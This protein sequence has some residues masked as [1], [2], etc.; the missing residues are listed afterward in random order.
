MKLN[1][2][3]GSKGP[4][5]CGPSEPDADKKYYPSLH[6]DEENPVD[7]PK[8][9]TMVV[10]FRKTGSSESEYDGKSKYSCTLEIRKIVSVDSSDAEAPA[11]SY[12]T[13]TGS[14][15][16]KLRALAKQVVDTEAADEE[17]D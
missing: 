6:I 12:G 11:K 14:A 10:E 16:D 5:C 4:T 15:L 3:L 7:L 17:T 2:D 13:E 1:L 9:G 8:S